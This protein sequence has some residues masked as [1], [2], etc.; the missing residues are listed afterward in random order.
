MAIQSM[1][2]CAAG[3]L[4]R[5]LESPEDPTLKSTSTQQAAHRN[6][7]CQTLSCSLELSVYHC[8]NLLG[9][10][11]WVS[12][13]PFQGD[14]ASVSQ[15]PKG[16]FT[17]PVQSACSMKPILLMLAASCAQLSHRQWRCLQSFACQHQRGKT[18]DCHVIRA[19]QH[20][21]RQD[22]QDAPHFQP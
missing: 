14:G 8:C 6:G 7:M 1:T 3:M 2:L 15:V 20:G 21:R 5:R 18:R 17:S 11:D 12:A 19:R 10:I 22:P 9:N 16:P 4:H 13:A